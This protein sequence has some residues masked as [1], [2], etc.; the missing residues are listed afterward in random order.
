MKDILNGK[1]KPLKKQVGALFELMKSE[2]LE[3]L[4][5]KDK[6]LHV[7]LKRKGRKTKQQVIEVPVQQAPQQEAAAQQAAAN[8]AAPAGETVKSPITG[9]FYRAPSPAMPPFVKE[10]DFADAGKTMCIVEAMKVMNEIKAEK[11]IKII[12]ILVENGKPVTSGQDL[13]VIE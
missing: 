2:N 13:F 9:V 11:R 5:L 8:G 12:K 3:E 7:H 10:G 4:E 6:D 1:E